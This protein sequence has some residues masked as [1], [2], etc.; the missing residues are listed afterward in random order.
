[1][2][3]DINGYYYD[4]DKQWILYEDEHGNIE[5]EEDKDE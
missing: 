3:R 2:E 5:M 1:M 4:G